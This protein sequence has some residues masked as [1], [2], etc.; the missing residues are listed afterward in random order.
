MN[1]LKNFSQAEY[2]LKEK[3]Q[4]ENRKPV[5]LP[6]ED[7]G[8][9]HRLREYLCEQIQIANAKNTITKTEYVHLRKVVLTRLTLLNA[10]RGSEPARMLLTEFHERNSM[11]STEDQVTGMYS[12]TFMMGKGCVF[13]ASA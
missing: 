9:L 1:Y 11:I 8:D 5:S 3:L 13:G 4:R 12:I 2:Q 6:D 10:Q 7:E